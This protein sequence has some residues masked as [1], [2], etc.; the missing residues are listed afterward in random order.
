MKKKIN[1]SDVTLLAATSVDIDS[2]QESLKICTQNI[3]FGAVKFL[4]SSP[5]KIKY[6]DVEYISIPPI[7]VL[8]YSKFIIEDLNKYFTTSHC[9]VTQADGFI[10]NFESWTNE[11]LNFDYIGAPWTKTLNPKP[12][13][14]INLDENIVGNGGFSLRSKKLT[15]IT[16]KINYNSLKF[17]LPSE[18]III[19]HYLYKQMINDGIKF[20]PPELAAKFSMEHQKT[21]KTYG[22]DSSNVFGFH[23]KHLMNYFK[24]RFMLK[25]LIS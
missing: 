7:T 9:L 14:T 5:P 22:Y 2:T 11:F 3:K 16:S 19:C 8:D 25:N 6:P 23:G 10:V 13:L 20:A 21:N 24:K 18:D 15:T 4:S 1:I 17:P 12:N